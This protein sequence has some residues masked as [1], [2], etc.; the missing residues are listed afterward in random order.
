[1]HFILCMADDVTDYDDSHIEVAF[2]ADPTNKEKTH[3]C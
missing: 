3:L 1:M 2:S